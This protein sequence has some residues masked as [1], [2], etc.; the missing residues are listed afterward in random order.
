M[1]RS[2]DSGTMTLLQ[3]LCVLR[4]LGEGRAQSRTFPSTKSLQSFLELHGAELQISLQ[5]PGVQGRQTDQAGRG[6][7]RWGRDMF[8]LQ[9]T[10]SKL[11][12]GS[13]C[14]WLR[15]EQ[16]REPWIFKR[17]WWTLIFGHV[18]ILLRER[19]H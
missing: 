12:K 15:K 16:V 5:V 7:S 9:S 11:S 18:Q 14:G 13:C 4:V 3:K 8:S 17:I 19:E 2:E 10:Y 6:S 1:G